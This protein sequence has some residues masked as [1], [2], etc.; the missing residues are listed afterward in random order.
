MDK[1]GLISPEELFKVL[2]D[3][4]SGAVDDEDINDIVKAIDLDGDGNIHL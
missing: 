1:S 2:K 4:T 3:L